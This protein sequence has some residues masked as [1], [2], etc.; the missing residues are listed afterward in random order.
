M[1]SLFLPEQIPPRVRF[2][3]LFSHLPALTQKTNARGR[4]PFPRNALLRALIYQ[5]L[6]GIPSL[7]ELAFELEN[8]PAVQAACGFATFQH[9]PSRERFSR[10]L[11]TTPHQD[12]EGLRKRLVRTLIEEKIISGGVCAMDSCPIEA[13][14]RENNLKT[15][16]KARFDKTKL[17][18]GD[19]DA[20]LG[21]KIHFLQPLPSK[22]MFYWGYRNHIVI[23]AESELPLC[24]I[25][26]PNDRGEKKVAIPMLRDLSAL[27]LPVSAVTGDAN[28]DSEDILS[29]ISLDMK[30]QPI[31]PHNPRRPSKKSFHL[32][33]DTVLCPAEL[34]MHRKG[35]MSSKGRIYLQY[36]CPLHWDKA[37]RGKYLLCPAGHPKFVNQ[38]GCNYLLRLSPSIRDTIDYGSLR[39]KTI[40]HQRT[41]VE[42][43]FSRLLAIA[44][45]NPTVVGLVATRN[46]CTIAHITMLL[47]ALTAYSE[48]FPDKIRYVKS[49]V[50]R[51]LV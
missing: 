27:A 9:P 35:R 50:P 5:R 3:K 23:D 24:E 17:P 20:R 19:P 12:L 34:P 7:I 25:T 38:K 1:K 4:P 37:Y 49:F 45:Q 48:G 40:Y 42:R 13:N 21:V 6:R 18:R 26:H 41:S 14:V 10:F 33:R 29:Y 31:I 43:G 8:N 30:A 32:K 16:V 51:Y 46:H 11:Q 44:M 36:T 2:E 15:A 47:V 28:Y 22:V 39:F